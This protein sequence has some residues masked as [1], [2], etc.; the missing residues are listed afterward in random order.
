MNLVQQVWQTGGI[1]CRLEVLRVS[2]G[3][4]PQTELPVRRRQTQ[5]PSGTPREKQHPSAADAHLSC[6]LALSHEGRSLDPGKEEGRTL[7]G[8]WGSQRSRCPPHRTTL[9]DPETTWSTRSRCHELHNVSTWERTKPRT[10]TDSGD[11]DPNSPD[12]E[13]DPNGPDPEPNSPDPNC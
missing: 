7:R 13:P 12:P 2:W 10:D 4:R 5:T 9:E 11:P 6:W 3:T 1:T 8:V